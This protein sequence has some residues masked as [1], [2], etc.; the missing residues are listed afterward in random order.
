MLKEDLSKIKEQRHNISDTE[1][2]GIEE[3]K[4]L[5][6]INEEDYYVPIKLGVR[7]MLIMAIQNMKAEEINMLIYRQKNILT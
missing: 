1:Y 3:I 4:Q 7:L 6:N 5:F 2:R